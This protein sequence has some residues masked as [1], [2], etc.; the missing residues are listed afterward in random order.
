MLNNS[1]YKSSLTL[2]ASALTLLTFATTATAASLHSERDGDGDLSDNGLAPTP[3]GE[4]TVGSNTLNATFNA[5]SPDYFTFI[6]P[7]GQA[8]T[9]IVLNSWTAFE[10]SGSLTFEDIAFFAVKT[11]PTFDFDLAAGEEGNRAE[12]LLGWSHLRTTQLLDTQVGD[13]LVKAS[14]KI[15]LEISLSGTNPTTNG[16]DA[17]YKAEAASDPY[18]GLDNRDELTERLFTLSDTWESGATG[19]SPPFLGP[20]EYSFWLRQGSETLIEVDLDFQTA[21]QPAATPEPFSIFGLAT[22]IGLGI[23]A[24]KQRS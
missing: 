19:F 8:L 11:G 12:G 9:K 14:D 17:L 15:L 16:I 22:T 10:Q 1:L 3:L 23:L 2:A 6:V 5:A 21:E 7:E 4:L 20:G 13:T 24:K 18:A